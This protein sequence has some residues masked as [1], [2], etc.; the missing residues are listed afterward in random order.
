MDFSE[1]NMD[2]SDN[3]T[4]NQDEQVESW[5]IA[6]YMKHLSQSSSWVTKGAVLS[7]SFYISVVS[8]CLFQIRF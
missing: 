8:K 4:D 7:H 5:L 1:N 6:L 2:F 3:L